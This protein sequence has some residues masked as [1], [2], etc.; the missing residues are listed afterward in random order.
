MYP[1]YESSPPVHFHNCKRLRM[2]CCP[3]RMVCVS[4]S[5]AGAPL[6]TRRLRSIIKRIQ[7]AQRARRHALPP[8]LPHTPRRAAQRAAPKV[9]AVSQRAHIFAPLFDLGLHTTGLQS[10]IHQRARWHAVRGHERGLRG[11]FAHFFVLAKGFP[12][13]W[14]SGGAT[15]LYHHKTSLELGSLFLK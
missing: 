15:R 3:C 7:R 8:T 12:C 14:L 13:E 1:L 10:R 11:P 2:V 9:C 4:M 5:C 6:K